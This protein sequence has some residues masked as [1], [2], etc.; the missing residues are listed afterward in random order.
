MDYHTLSLASRFVKENNCGHLLLDDQM[1]SVLGNYPLRSTI[2][3]TIF[4]YPLYNRSNSLH[5][6][7]INLVIDYI[8]NHN[9][10]N[11]IKIAILQSSPYADALRG[12]MGQ[13]KR[14]YNNENEFI[15][16]FIKAFYECALNSYYT[17][18]TPPLRVCELPH[19]IYG[20]FK[21]SS[22]VEGHKFWASHVYGTTVYI[23]KM[24]LLKMLSYVIK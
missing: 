5:M 6:A 7:I 2:N 4:D 11:S 24:T 10:G 12:A 13:E 19:M 21:W 14:K 23:M 8:I 9:L 15:T 16:E 22:T 18:R 3:E 20:T 17:Q 1:L